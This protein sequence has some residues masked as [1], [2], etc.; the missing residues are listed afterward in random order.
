VPRT[1]LALPSDDRREGV[2]YPHGFVVS[3]A[4]DGYQKTVDDGGPCGVRW[5]IACRYSFT[6]ARQAAE[7]PTDYSTTALRAVE[8]VEHALTKLADLA[9][10]LWRAFRAGG[11]AAPCAWWLRSR[12]SRNRDPS[13]TIPFALA[14]A[15]RFEPWLR[16]RTSA[17]DN[18]ALGQP[19]EKIDVA[20][21]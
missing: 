3:A 2:A 21:A 4:A 1:R 5:Q 19:A 6:A 12:P 10:G 8:H 16:V 15:M 7:L 17:T 14:R 20:R 13:S 9:V 11:G 18:L